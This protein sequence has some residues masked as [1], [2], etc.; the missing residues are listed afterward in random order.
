MKPHS[1]EK[2][3]K[4][5]KR[6]RAE[7]NPNVKTEQEQNLL[8]NDGQPTANS[9]IITNVIIYDVHGEENEEDSVR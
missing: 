4:K 8:N 6:S 7:T 5:K 2:K 1:G 9:I 3:R